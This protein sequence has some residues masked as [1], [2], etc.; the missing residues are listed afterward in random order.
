MEGKKTPQKRRLRESVKE[1]GN[2]KGKADL[3]KAKVDRKKK[4]NPRPSGKLFKGKR[5]VGTRQE[6][7]RRTFLGKKGRLPSK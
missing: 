6:V 3:Q 1:L 7:L 4:D 2:L 5:T